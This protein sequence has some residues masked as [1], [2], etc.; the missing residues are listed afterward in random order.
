[1]AFSATPREQTIV[2]TELCFYVNGMP[3]RVAGRDAFLTL[4]DYLRRNQNLTGTKIVCSEGDCGACSVL[5]GRIHDG[6]LHYA[7]VDSCIQFLYQVDGAHVVTVEGLKK[8]GALHPVQQAMIDCHGSQC[9]FCTPGFV[10]TMASLFENGG[11]RREEPLTSAELRDALSGNLCR[12]T[13]YV[14]IIEAGCSIDPAS[15]PRMKNVFDEKALVADLAERV[16]EEVRIE[17]RDAEGHDLVVYL[18]LSWEAAARFKAESEETV[19]IAGATDIGVQRN[20]GRVTPRRILSLARVE[21]DD[22]ISVA[23]GLLTIGARTVWS[24]VERAMRDLIP[25]YYNILLRFGGPQIRNAGTVGGNLVNASPIADSIPF[26][27]VTETELELISPSGTRR[28]PIE[29]FYL[30]YKKLDL[31]Q[32]ELLARV[33]ARLPGDGE[34]L[35]LYKVS[36]RK[37]LDISTFTAAIAV[38]LDGSTVASARIAYGGV[39]PVVL[40][41]PQTEA[42]LAGKPFT[43]ETMRAAGRT[44]RGE[45]TP[46]TDVRGSAAYRS[47]L[48][49]NILVRFYHD[50]AA[51]AAAV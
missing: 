10:T 15:V 29:K 44:A 34:I 27:F 46:I 38:Q 21:G 28:V 35:K 20:K 13:G 1:M 11:T 12:C 19:V 2:R 43:E 26:H 16:R 5:V 24:A 7:A 41:L 22:T 3:H 25:D 47:Q 8:N 50:V 31:K 4:S 32:D 18:P 48:A 40:R 17:A 51:Q 23:D 6:V 9:G 49:E 33:V 37:N 30:G 45:I 14:Q 39:G 42:F 36:K